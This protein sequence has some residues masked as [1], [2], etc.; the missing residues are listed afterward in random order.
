MQTAIPSEL[1]QFIDREVASGK[2]RSRDEVIAETLR[3]LRE[4]E[5]RREPLVAELQARIDEWDRG[6]GIAAQ[7][8]F[9]EL[10]LQ[11]S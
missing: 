4:R 1:E 7:A 8:V 6:N 9:E 2:Y 11:M 5:R 10:R 3:I